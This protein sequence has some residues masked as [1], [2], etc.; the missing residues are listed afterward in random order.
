MRFVQAVSAYLA[1]NYKMNT[2]GAQEMIAGLIDGLISKD[3]LPELQK[4]LK[5]AESLEVELTN[6]IADLEKGD[7]E[8][9]IKAA[10]EVGQIIKEVPEDLAEC[11]D[12]QDDVT[13]LEAWADLFKHPTQLVQT[14]FQ[15]VV[16]NMGPVQADIATLTSDYSSAKYFNVGE[17]IA[18]ITILAL[19]Q[20]TKPK[21]AEPIELNF[22]GIKNLALF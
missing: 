15:N 10:Q 2:E 20:I 18:D 9:I 14:I 21:H 4:C 1:T 19:G 16:S 7:L 17:D 3:D 22:D 6:V 8:S 13:K 5:N 12:I 11:K